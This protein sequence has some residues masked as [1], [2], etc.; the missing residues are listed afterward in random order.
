MLLTLF[1]ALGG[2]FGGLGNWFA[3]NPVMA[4]ILAVVALLVLLWF[5]KNRWEA[6]IIKGVR[7]Q[8][9]E[10]F[11]KQIAEERARMI[12][13]SG[14]IITEERRNA[15]AALEARD[16]GEHYP[17][18]DSLPDDLKTLA[19]GRARPDRESGS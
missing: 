2:W 18:Y 6:N 10:N 14:K 3:K 4:K 13:R 17:T 8:E 11:A 12:E 16:S 19:G 1:S 15:D 7:R 5:G 9:R